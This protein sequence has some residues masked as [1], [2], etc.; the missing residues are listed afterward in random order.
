MYT[1]IPTVYRALLKSAVRELIIRL[2]I[3]IRKQHMLEEGQSSKA[4]RNAAKHDH[5]DGK[6]LFSGCIACANTVVS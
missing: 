4:E 6:G 3:P 1:L 2:F 5:N